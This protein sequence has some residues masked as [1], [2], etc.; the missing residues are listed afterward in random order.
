MYFGHMSSFKKRST[1]FHFIHV[2]IYISLEEFVSKKFCDLVFLITFILFL[3]VLSVC[4][5]PTLM[6]VG[7]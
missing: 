7:C 2:L 5:V 1:V 6:M 3:H 4:Q